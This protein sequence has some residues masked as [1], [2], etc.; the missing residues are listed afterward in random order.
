MNNGIR[1]ALAGM[2]CLWTYV[3][4][5]APRPP[6]LAVLEFDAPERAASDQELQLL[7]DAFRSAVIETVAGRYQVMTRDTMQELVPPEQMVCLAGACAATIGRALQASHVMAGT[8]RRLDD[9][10]ILTIEA[11]ETVSG[12]VLGTRQL[13][14]ART[15]P[16]RRRVLADAPALVTQWLQLDP[17]ATRRE[18]DTA[19]AQSAS[20][21]GGCP[22][23][24]VR[25]E[26][27]TFSMGGAS[28]VLVFDNE[29]PAHTVTVSPFCLGRTEVTQAEWTAVMGFNPSETR[30]ELFPVHNVSWVDAVAFA[31]RRSDAEGLPR[32]MRDEGTLERG[33]TGYRLPTEAE[34]E[35]A[36]RAIPPQ[37]ALEEVAW[38]ADNSGGVPHPVGTRAPDGHGISDL[39]GNVA[40]WVWDGLGRYGVAPAID[41]TGPVSAAQRVVRGGAF[42]V[43]ETLVRPGARG[44]LAPTVR[45][46]FVG[47]RLA[48][49]VVR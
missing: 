40:E 5:A 10:L 17:A 8:V 7:T 3:S 48:R 20:R 23:E 6:L 38:F 13:V 11:Y 43:D 16:L 24:M 1:W 19:R 12:R 9:E 36:A 27:G 2:L 34:W 35:L 15:G 49:S 25:V 31:N 46:P 14:E 37:A 44:G 30:G 21:V 32:A 41:P 26:G 45:K 33:A 4:A 39:L 47:F 22:A 29:L 42:G 28:A 18:A